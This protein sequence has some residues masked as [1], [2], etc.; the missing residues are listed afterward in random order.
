MCNVYKISFNS[1]S[2]EILAS[3]RDTDLIHSIITKYLL[4][5]YCVPTII[6]D[7]EITKTK[8]IDIG[9]FCPNYSWGK[10]KQ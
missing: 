6:L 4:T 2:M 10:N 8:G 5:A 9:H 1:L 3:K 7:I